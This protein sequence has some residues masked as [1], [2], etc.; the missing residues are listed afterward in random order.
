MPQRYT[1]LLPQSS[2][3]STIL[4]LKIAIALLMIDSIIELSFIS[5]MVSWLHTRA[6]RDFD[7]EYNGDT[8]P[9]H[10]KPLNFLL[11]QGHTSNGAAGTA[12]VLI[13]LGGILAL[14]LRTRQSRNPN[15]SHKLST[16]YYYFWLVMTLLSA[17]L[18]LSA[19]IYTFLITYQH[20]GQTINLATA[21]SLNNRPYPNQVPYPLQEWTPEN[22]FKAVLKLELAQENVSTNNILLKTIVENDQLTS[23]KDV[24]DIELHLRIMEAWRWNL[25]PLFALGL[26]VSMLAGVDGLVRRK[27]TR[28]QRGMVEGKRVS[29]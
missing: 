13:G 15:R 8:F 19:L 17:L 7:I 14:W 24:N 6:G 5:S 25:I 9:L 21:S 18:S 23:R 29:I 2:M 27:A 1:P 16:A 20:S 3:A 28:Y 22:W 4:A 10:G 11:N 12:F 26:L